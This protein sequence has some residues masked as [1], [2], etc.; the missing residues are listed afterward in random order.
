MRAYAAACVALG[1][2]ASVLA[3]GDQGTGP[4]QAQLVGTWQVTR[5]E[6][7]STQG[8]GTVDLVAG[9]GSGTL[10]IGADDTLRLS[11]TP[12]SGTPVSLT[13]TYRIEGIDLL[14]VTPAGVTWYWAFDMAL[15]GNTLTLDGGSGQYDFDHDGQ[16]DPATWNLTMTR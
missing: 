1:G 4:S 8:R 5:C 9:G 16:P 3:C 2:L 6:Y 14:Q 11:V 10:V 7:V 12:A 15:S 13:A